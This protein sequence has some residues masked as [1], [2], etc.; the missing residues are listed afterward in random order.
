M[1]IVQSSIGEVDVLSVSGDIDG[2]TAPALQ[3]QVLATAKPDCKML[4]DLGGVTFMSSAGLR[5]MLLLYR[6]ISSNKGK[7]ILVGMS[8]DLRSTMQA[9]GFLKYFS[10]ADTIDDGV[11]SLSA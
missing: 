8:E 7:V 1:E 2:A 10:L 3:E 9:T 5:V 6:Q 4:L 11:A